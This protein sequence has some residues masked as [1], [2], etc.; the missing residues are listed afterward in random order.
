MIL[1]ILENVKSEDFFVPEL[2]YKK[3][4]IHIK[5]INKNIMLAYLGKSSQHFLHLNS[6]L[7]INC[8]EKVKHI[9]PFRKS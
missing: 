6:I 1:L 3:K 2:A 8:K 4:H 7:A 9:K 5:N